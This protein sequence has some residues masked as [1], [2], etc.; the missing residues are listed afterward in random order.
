MDKDKKYIDLIKKKENIQ[1]LREYYH[2]H[3]CSPDEASSYINML[4][5]KVNMEREQG[6]QE[7]HPQPPGRGSRREARFPTRRHEGQD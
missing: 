1:A 3:N 4:I 7:N 6:N 5:K 2:D